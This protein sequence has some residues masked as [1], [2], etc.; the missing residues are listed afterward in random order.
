MTPGRFRYFAWLY[1]TPAQRA[2]LQPLFAIESEILDSTHLDHNVAHLRLQWWHG[3]FER[4]AQK[5]AT[6]PLA[7]NWLKRARPPAH[8]YRICA[9]S[10][11]LP[12]LT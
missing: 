8:R 6:H 5:Q 1:S 10:C 3:E 7:S 11:D 12:I 4:L 9:N 2:V